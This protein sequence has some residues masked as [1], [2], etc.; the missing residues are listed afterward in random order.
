MLLAEGISNEIPNVEPTKLFRVLQALKTKRSLQPKEGTGF[1][2]KLICISPL[3]L[4]DK[5]EMSGAELRL[6]SFP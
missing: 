2:G 4:K 6:N 5:E 3:T 1:K